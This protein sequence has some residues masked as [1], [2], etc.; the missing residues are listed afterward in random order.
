MG[1]GK[2]G[3]SLTISESLGMDWRAIEG[4]EN[5]AAASQESLSM[6]L[7]EG[8]EGGEGGE[9]IEKFLG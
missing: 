6:W 5:A 9:A 7:G 1:L 2:V 3:R 4:R 8:G